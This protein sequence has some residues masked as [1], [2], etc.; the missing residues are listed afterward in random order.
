MHAVRLV[1]TEEVD[2]GPN[3]TDIDKSV[4]RIRDAIHNCVRSCLAGQFTD[5][6]DIILGADN[7]RAMRKYDE[8]SLGRQQRFEICNV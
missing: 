5:G 3:R 6:G 4:R 8:L 7:V 2:V 1:H